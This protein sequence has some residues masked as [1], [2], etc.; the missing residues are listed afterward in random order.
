M[1]STQAC[2]LASLGYDSRISQAMWL[3]NKFT[4]HSPEVRRLRLGY[5][6]NGGQG[7]AA[8]LGSRLP[9]SVCIL[10]RLRERE[11]QRETERERQR[12]RE[13]ETQRE[14]ERDRVRERGGERVR[15][16]VR[17]RER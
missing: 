1:I 16:T 17:Q 13:K 3:L 9:P 4:Y 12:E 6:R 7:R 10:T 5:Q 15:E 11:R 14:R 2:V 8:F